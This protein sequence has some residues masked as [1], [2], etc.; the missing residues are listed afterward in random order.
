MDEPQV[1]IEDIVVAQ[2][3][4]CEPEVLAADIVESIPCEDAAK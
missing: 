1:G 3:V 2:L 4:E